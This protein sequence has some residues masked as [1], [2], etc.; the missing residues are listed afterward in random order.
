MSEQLVLH[1]NLRVELIAMVAEDRRVSEELAADGRLFKCYRPKMAD[2]HKR[3]GKR[4]GEIVDKVGW[5]GKTLVGEEGAEAAWL[6]L[7][8]D[9]ANPTLQ[10]HCLPLLREAV[11]KGEV[12][13]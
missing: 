4:L 9:I 12:S 5:P 11:A 7:Q 13:T 10:R 2:V 6:I 1:I 8:H 3:N